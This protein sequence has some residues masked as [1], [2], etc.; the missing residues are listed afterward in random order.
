MKQKLQ[1]LLLL[2]LIVTLLSSCF[3][4]TSYVPINME[5]IKLNIPIK[6]SNIEIIDKRLEI[7][8]GEDIQI[9]F[10]SSIKNKKWKFYPKLNLEHEKLIN[11][12]IR[13]NTNENS[14]IYGD[15]KVYINS[16]CKEFEGTGTSEIERIYMSIDVELV[17]NE[18]KYKGV[19]IDT[20]KHQSGDASNKHFE[21]L[22]QTSMQNSIVQ[23]LTQIRSQYYNSDKMINDCLTGEI[24]KRILIGNNSEI[25][26]LSKNE[27]DSIVI[28][29]IDFNLT[30]NWEFKISSNLEGKITYIES[31]REGESNVEELRRLLKYLYNIEIR[32]SKIDQEV[33]CRKLS[34][35]MKNN[36]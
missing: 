15:L 16:A 12:T 9:P 34:V 20:F 14:N 21:Q 11:T 23:C 3:R 13:N 18:K 17:M 27:I 22:Y 10:I 8:E 30:Q 36:H 1:L 25:I 29:N 19:A 24:E 31:L 7:S 28:K 4:Y 32:E 33:N 5:Q 26:I 2:S 6:A 35:R